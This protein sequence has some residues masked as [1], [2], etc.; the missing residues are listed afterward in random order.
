MDFI[1]QESLVISISKTKTNEVEYS[2]TKTGEGKYLT[3]EI[4]TP[5]ITR[6]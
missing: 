6:G 1:F 3:V 4:S 2:E 5:E